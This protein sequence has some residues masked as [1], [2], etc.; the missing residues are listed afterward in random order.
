MSRRAL[1]SL[2]LCAFLASAA[3]PAF[4]QEH[5]NTVRGFN[6]STGFGG[7]D[8]DSVNPFNGNLGYQLNL[9]YNNSV[10]DHQQRDTGTVVYTQALPNRAGNAGIVALE[11]VTGASAISGAAGG[12]VGGFIDSA[13]VSWLVDG[14]RSASQ[15]LGSGARGAFMAQFLVVWAEG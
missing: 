14:N 3:L 2:S 1:L 4:A 5:P 10:W 9:V 11:G 8:L 13:G 15:A 7:G 6:A 12:G